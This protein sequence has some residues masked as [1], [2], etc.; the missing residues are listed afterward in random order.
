MTA[1]E[2]A[3]LRALKNLNELFELGEA[4]DEQDFCA[5]GI[6]RS[7]DMREL[8]GEACAAWRKSGRELAIRERRVEAFVSDW[9]TGKRRR[10]M[11]T[12]W[13]PRPARTGRRGPRARK[14]S[15]REGGEALEE[16]GKEKEE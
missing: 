13:T 7:D 4:V 1:T 9:K 10:V 2:D 15:P 11:V 8:I 3:R 14:D 5:W 12:E 16:M 6:Q